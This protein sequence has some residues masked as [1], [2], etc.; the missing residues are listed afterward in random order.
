MLLL[1]DEF[2]VFRLIK[3]SLHVYIVV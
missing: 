1:C 3:V 2:V